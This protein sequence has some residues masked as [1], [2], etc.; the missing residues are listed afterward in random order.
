[1]SPSTMTGDR[2]P[3]AEGYVKIGINMKARLENGVPHSADGP[4][5]ILCVPGQADVH[6]YYTH[7]NKDR[8]GGPAVQHT[9]PGRTNEW[10]VDG[11]RVGPTLRGFLRESIRGCDLSVGSEYIFT[12]DGVRHIVTVVGG[13]NRA[14]SVIGNIASDE[15]VIRMH[16]NAAGFLH[17]DDG[18]AVEYMGDQAWIDDEWWCDGA[19]CTPTTKMM[20]AYASRTIDQLV[21]DKFAATVKVAIDEFIAEEATATAMREAQSTTAALRET[22]TTATGVDRTPDAN[23]DA[24][25]D[26]DENGKDEVPDADDHDEGDDEGKPVCFRLMLDGRKTWRDARNAYHRG[27]DRPAVIYPDGHDE[28]Y[29]H[30]RMHRGGDKPDSV[31]HKTGRMAWYSCGVPRRA[32]GGPTI[33]EA[34]STQKWHDQ[35]GMF[36]RP[37]LDGCRQPTVIRPDG[38]HEFHTHGRLDFKTKP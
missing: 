22:L 27:G 34:D 16:Y 23:D 31:N 6:M 30:G 4:A 10:W 21:A 5:V 25:D 33:V 20:M 13:G 7:G 14:T 35:E 15:P 36:H 37:S 3:D 8:V 32:T 28:Y 26:A 18:P 9:Q 11:V 19:K 17:R 2:T 29:R 1:M 12:C 24:D 38:T